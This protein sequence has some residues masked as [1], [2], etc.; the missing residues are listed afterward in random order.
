M[1][2]FLTANRACGSFQLPADGSTIESLR[3]SNTD[4]LA[5]LRVRM[6]TARTTTLAFIHRN[7]SI[8]YVLQVLQVLLFPLSQ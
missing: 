4:L 7:T 8:G 3:Q 6:W 2:Q 1:T 5:F